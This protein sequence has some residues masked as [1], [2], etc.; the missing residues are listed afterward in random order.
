MTTNDRSPFADIE[1]SLARFNASISDIE[2]AY[3]RISRQ[4]DEY[5]LTQTVPRNYLTEMAGNLAHE[6]RNPLAGI[7]NLVELLSQDPES[8]TSRIDGILNG[9]QRIDKIVENLIVFSKPVVLQQVRCN[10]YDIL[11][12]AI[13]TVKTEYLTECADRYRFEACTDNSTFV[14]NIDPV[15]V[16][17][18]LQNILSNAVTA[19]PDGGTILMRLAKNE[20][21][22]LLAIQDEGAGL[23]EPDCEKPFYPFYTT[24]TYGMGMGLPTSRLILEKHGGRVWME[25]TE[26]Q[27]L[28]VNV[29]LPIE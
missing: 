26:N 9:I 4:I 23:Q 6:I 11:Q 8:G 21:G 3:G 20:A 17:Q 2:R 13:E 7:A 27:G 24:K 19:M 12:R 14:V 28:T 5:G 1:R 29:T 16:L 18:A 10:F 22:V 15:L 25:P